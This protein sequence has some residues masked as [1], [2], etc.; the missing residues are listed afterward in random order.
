MAGPI[1]IPRAM[2]KAQVGAR[3]AF[4]WLG[5]VLV[6]FLLALAAARLVGLAARCPLVGQR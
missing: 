1:G 2:M 3:K 5:P 6:W 4:H